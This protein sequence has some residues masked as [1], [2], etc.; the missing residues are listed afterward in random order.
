[1]IYGVTLLLLM[2]KIILSWLCFR[3]MDIFLNFLKIIQ[4]FQVF[5]CRFSRIQGNKS[6]AELMKNFASE[7][8]FAARRSRKIFQAQHRDLLKL[9]WENAYLRS[10]SRC[11][12]TVAN[13]YLEHFLIIEKTF[14]FL[15]IQSAIKPTLLLDA[16][17]QMP[18]C[19]ECNRSNWWRFECF[20]ESES[21]VTTP[22]S[23]QLKLPIRDIHQSYGWT[24]IHAG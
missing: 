19:T 15:F 23:G 24:R 7:A 13:S 2:Y 12:R 18:W 4:G 6:G 8:S 20:Y 3:E 1:M 11:N 9:R 16:N 5:V 17:V 22:K 10:F 14:V 21:P